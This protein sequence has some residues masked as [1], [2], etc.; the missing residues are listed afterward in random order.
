MENVCPANQTPCGEKEPQQYRGA[1]RDRTVGLL[2]AI[3]G[4]P[5]SARTFNALVATNSASITPIASLRDPDRTHLRSVPGKLRRADRGIGPA[6]P[7][8]CSAEVIPS[9]RGKQPATRRQPPRD[10][11][12]RVDDIL[13]FLP[14]LRGLDLAVPRRPPRPGGGRPGALD[15]RHYREALRALRP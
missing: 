15:A 5:S 12:S 6:P 13:E 7:I 11:G 8:G 3:S 2:S 4:K 14:A 10:V 1:E 9:Q